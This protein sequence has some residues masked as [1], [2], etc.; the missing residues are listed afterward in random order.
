MTRKTDWFNNLTALIEDRRNTPYRLG[1][2]DCCTFAA[3]AVLAMT[4]NDPAK[5]VRGTY[6]TPEQAEAI[7]ESN[8][9]HAGLLTKYLGESKGPNCA[10]R[11]DLVTFITPNGTDSI[12]VCLGTTFACPGDDGLNIFDIQRAIRS[13]QVA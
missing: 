4:G 8:G 6:S 2:N 7:I 11:G 1:T 10:R 13:W 12:G 9:G 5:D 3:D